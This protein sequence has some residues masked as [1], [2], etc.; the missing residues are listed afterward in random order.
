MTAMWRDRFFSDIKWSRND[1]ETD[2]A[3]PHRVFLPPQ[4]D[5][6]TSP[7]VGLKHADGNWGVSTRIE[8]WSSFLGSAGRFMLLRCLCVH[9]R[10]P[11]RQP[12]LRRGL[13]MAQGITLALITPVTMPG[14]TSIAGTTDISHINGTTDISLAHRARS[15]VRHLFRRAG[16]PTP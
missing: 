4:D 11:H 8:L 9:R 10:S 3:L 14:A 13:I 1:P 2:V 7:D 16:L 15:A 5:S 6:H 12:R